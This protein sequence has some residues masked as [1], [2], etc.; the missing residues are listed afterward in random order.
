[1]RAGS[2]AA[3]ALGERRRPAGDAHRPQ[4]IGVEHQL[5]RAVA[6]GH[7]PQR[8]DGESVQ[9]GRRGPLLAREPFGGLQH[10]APA[11]VAAIVADDVA[12]ERI[13][14]LHLG[15]DVEVA[16]GMQL[17]VDVCERLQPR[18]ELAAGA[19]HSLGHRT[20]QTMVT[21]EQGNDPVGLAELVLAQHHRPIPVQPHR[22]S[23][24]PL[25][26]NIRARLGRDRYLS[27]SDGPSRLAR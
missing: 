22:H 8:P 15:D 17:D 4:Q 23:L 2:G 18:P 5:A 11:G 13:D 3:G 6:V 1:M 19:T 14:G 9:C 26:D 24:P 25:A 10:R 20:D 27:H 21:G 16:A 7:G 12:G